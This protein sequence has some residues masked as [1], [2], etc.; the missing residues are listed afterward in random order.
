MKLLGISRQRVYQLIE[1]GRLPVR[2]GAQRRIW[3]PLQAIEARLAGEQRL[4]STQCISTGEVAEFF[5]V[6]ERTVRDWQTRGYL[7]AT[8]INNRLCFNPA[9]VVAF[10]PPGEGGPGRSPARRGTR[11][12]RGRY[13]PPP[14]G[15]T[16]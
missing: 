14:S 9:E 12:I 15:G 8:K 1:M 16:D 3:V 11:T 6:D 10:V 13:F 5:G 4:D 7:H 2:R